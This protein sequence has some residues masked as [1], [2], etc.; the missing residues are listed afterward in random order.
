MRALGFEMKKEEVRKM[1]SDIHKEPTDNI[2][3]HEFTLMMTGKMGERDSEEEILKVLS[4]IISLSLSLSH[5]HTHS[6][7]PLGL[8]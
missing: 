1:L 3:F 2:D 7:S 4:L 5:I 6:L 8:F